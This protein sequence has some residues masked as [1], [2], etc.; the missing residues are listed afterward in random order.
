ML[1]KKTKAED[2]ALEGTSFRSSPPDITTGLNLNIRAG[3][4][5]GKTYLCLATAPEPIAYLNGDR[6]ILLAHV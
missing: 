6:V 2:P 1:K 5:V 3:E 4:K